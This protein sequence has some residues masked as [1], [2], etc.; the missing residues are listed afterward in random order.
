MSWFDVPVLH[1]YLGQ[2]LLWSFA[3][4]ELVK[5]AYMHTCMHACTRTPARRQTHRRIEELTRVLS[6]RYLC[7]GPI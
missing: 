7:W 3:K 2:R 4:A 6:F 5:V 1:G